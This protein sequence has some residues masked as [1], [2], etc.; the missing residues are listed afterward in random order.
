MYIG[1][2]ILLIGITRGI[3]SELGV[4]I[5]TLRF[6]DYTRNVVILIVMVYYRE[7]IHIKIRKVECIEQSLGESR[8]K[9]LFVPS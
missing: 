4:P 9:L 5:T 6:S 1:F 7:R 2:I 8:C 3:T